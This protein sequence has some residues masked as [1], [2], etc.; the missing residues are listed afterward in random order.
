MV[1][2]DDEYSSDIHID[3]YFSLTLM[4]KTEV[5]QQT[6]RPELH[7]FISDVSNVFAK[8]NNSFEYWK[9]ISSIFVLFTMLQLQTWNALKLNL[10]YKCPLHHFL[11]L[12][13]QQSN[14]SNPD[15]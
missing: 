5:N 8:S 3:W 9:N 7:L 4:S 10:L 12:V 14:K 11:K 1:A 15:L 13:C 6:S 2:V